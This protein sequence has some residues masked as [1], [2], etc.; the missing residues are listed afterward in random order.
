MTRLAAWLT[1]ALSA[2]L[3]SGCDVA[4]RDTDIKFISITEAKTLF[5]RVQKGDSATAVFLDPRP[6]VEFSEG[7]IP[8]ARN[9]TL[10]TIKP[11]S[12][13]DPR[14]QRFANLVI[15]G[16]DPASATAR[17]LTKRLIAVG[18]GDVRCFAGGLEEWKQRGYPIETS[19]LPPDPDAPPPEVSPSGR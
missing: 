7:H 15:Y 10:A 1:A 17:G 8:G 2:C 12:K 11:A 4:T 19:P 13:V 18:Y 9:I 6:A 5:D 3:L 14:L 16:N